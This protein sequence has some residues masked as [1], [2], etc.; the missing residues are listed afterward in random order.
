MSCKQLSTAG[1]RCSS[2]QRRPCRRN[3]SKRHLSDLNQLKRKPS[4]GP[5]ASGNSLKNVAGCMQNLTGSC[6]HNT[7][8]PT[9]ERSESKTQCQA[10]GP[11]LAQVILSQTLLRALRHAVHNHNLKR[12]DKSGP[13]GCHPDTQTYPSR[14]GCCKRCRSVSFQLKRILLEQR[15]TARMEQEATFLHIFGSRRQCRQSSTLIRCSKLLS[16]LGLILFMA[17]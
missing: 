8:T 12:R 2:R 3:P 4:V 5:A 7:H 15:R 1:L 6:Q 14:A 11:Y 16:L 17:A 10:W 9:L 13:T